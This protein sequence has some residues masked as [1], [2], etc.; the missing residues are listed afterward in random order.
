MAG[1]GVF[2]KSD[3]DIIYQADHNAIQ[4]VIAGVVNTYYGNALSSSQLSGKPTIQ[5][6]HMDKLRL[7]INKA[8]KHITGANS[9]IN[10]VSV[11]STIT[12]EDWNAYKTAADYCETNKATVASGQL[13]SSV[14]SDTMTSNWNGSHSFVVQ[15]AWPTATEANYF[16]NAGGYFN[17]DVAGSNSSGSSKDDDWQNNILNAIS[18]Q[19]YTKTQWDSATNIDVY[20]YGNVTQYTE[21][22]C[23]ILV[24]K[25]GSTVVVTV[26]VNDADTGDQTG[27]G[28]AV[29]EDVTVDVGASIT[30]YKS[31]DAITVTDPTVTVTGTFVSGSSAPTYS[32]YLPY[33]SVNEGN[34]TPVVA[35]TTNVA[36]GTVLYWTINNGTTSDADFSAVNGSVTINS[37][38]GQINITA[39]S[40]GTAEGG[41]TFTVQLRTGSITG[42][43]VATSGSI[44]ITDASGSATPAILT[45]FIESNYV[46]GLGGTTFQAWSE[47]AFLTTGTSRVTIGDNSAPQTRSILPGEWLTTSPAAVS[48]PTAGLFDIELTPS[49]ATLAIDGTTVALGG[50][51]TTQSTGTSWNTRL[52][53][54]TQEVYRYLFV[55]VNSSLGGAVNHNATAYFTATIYLHGTNTV[56]TSSQI[57]LVSSAGSIGV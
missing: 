49:S 3:G 27:I 54:G 44:T 53:L 6:L 33:T 25:V 43:I 45:D 11:G 14:V 2:P 36:N 30:L 57:T 10:N 17:I 28:A 40:D 46:G 23:R 15:Y 29:D 21:N 9:T 41:Q 56:Q 38:S 18:T 24:Q 34:S 16:F 8:Y 37:N 20:E 39:V 1:E 4:S 51:R 22:Y 12:N 42:S 55:E 47:V 26:T 32:L 48:T 5:A 31:I 13:S 19:I 52:Q 50:D 35:L 7:D